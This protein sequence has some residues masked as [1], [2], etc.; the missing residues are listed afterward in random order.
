MQAFGVNVPVMVMLTYGAGAALAA[1]AGVLAAPVY[2]VQ[3][4]MGSNII[5]VVFAVVVVGC[6]GSIGGAIFTGYM[7]GIFEGLTQC[8]SMSGGGSSADILKDIMAAPLVRC[9][10]VQ[11]SFLGIS[12]AGWN[13]ILSTGAAL[14]IL[15][16]SIRRP[17]AA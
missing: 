5:I 13:A 3:P 7:L 17:R 1:L 15:W 16:L 11:F 4:L 6:M 2:Q 12:M 8:S 10:Q 9:D 14:V